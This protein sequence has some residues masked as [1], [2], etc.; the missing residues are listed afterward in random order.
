MHSLTC[1]ICQCALE[2]TDNSLRC[3]A[4]H[5]FDRARQGYW[6]LLAVQQKKSKD[7]G[8]N[9][10]MVAA[11]RA[12]LDSGHYKPMAGAI[13]ALL[14]STLPSDTQASVL[15][16]GCGE[17]Y[18]TD[19]WQRALPEHLFYGLDIS[20]H[21]VK[22]ACR[23]NKEICWLVAS[24]A[25]MPIPAQSLDALTVVFSRLMPT[26]FADALKPGGALILAWA[27]EDHLLELRQ[28]LY[29]EVKLAE[30]N[31][32]DELSEHFELEQKE[33]LCFDFTVSDPEQLHTLLLMTPH[34][35]RVN[36]QKVEHLLQQPALTVR[37]S[38]NIALLRKRPE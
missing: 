29:S 8:D 26:P 36:A 13:Q 20:K 30:S 15:D 25:N 3:Q 38:V 27:R 5:N 12:F 21:A 14:H 31:P 7:P 33:T 23:R 19:Q 16:M 17:G 34:G 28:Q 6:N 37:F 22:A 32:I 4:N 9:A 10:Q 1:P 24:G 11:R 18:Y 2:R 35:Q